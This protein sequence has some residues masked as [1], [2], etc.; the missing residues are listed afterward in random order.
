[1]E[2]LENRIKKDG[3]VLPGNILKVSSFLNHQIDTVLLDQMGAEFAR[4]YKDTPVTKILTIESSGIAVGYSVARQFGVPLVFAKK[5][6]SSNVNE[7]VYSTTVYSYTHGQNYN[8][9]VS[10]RFISPEDKILLVDDFL[11]NG[12]ALNGLIDLVEQAGAKVQGVC[13]A[14]EKG[15]QDGGKTIRERGYRVESAAI[16]EK[17]TDDG[18]IE[19]RKS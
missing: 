16:I 10:K 18:Q 9:V 1:M 14:I 17:M 11:A 19:F 2:L 8:V 4:L 15:F 7:D 5:H 13:I 3:E 6:Q 12:K